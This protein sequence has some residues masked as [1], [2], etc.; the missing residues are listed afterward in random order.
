MFYTYILLS[1]KDNKFYTGYANNLN[2]R[3]AEHQKG[4]VFSTKSRLPIKLVYYEAC[5]NKEDAIR[6]EKTLKSGRGKTYIKKRLNS[7]LSQC[8]GFGP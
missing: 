5:L 2:R 1:E 4:K 3:I 7:Y 6:R 8:S